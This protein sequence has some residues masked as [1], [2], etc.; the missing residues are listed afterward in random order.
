M[1]PLREQARVTHLSG[2]SVGG[3]KTVCI[4][5]D[6]TIYPWAELWHD[7]PPL[8]GAVAAVRKMRHDG[9]RIVILTS[10][11]SPTWWAADGIDGEKARKHVEALLER[12]GIPYDLL[13]AEKVPAHAYIDD[14]GYRF[15]G[16]WRDVEEFLGLACDC[17]NVCHSGGDCCGAER[18]A[19]L[20]FP[21]S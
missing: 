5:F 16:D 20:D 2:T 4:D 3:R 1:Q 19:F 8:P 13:T 10:R 14:R 11:M 21:T 6:A 18:C 15:E 17:P 7:S 9:W 12:D